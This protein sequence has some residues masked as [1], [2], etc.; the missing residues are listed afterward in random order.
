MNEIEKLKAE[1]EQL[2]RE[3]HW[4][5]AIL[6]SAPVLLSAKD[7]QGN[8]MFVSEHFKVLKGP[9]PDE[10]INKSVFD[11]FPAD[12]AEALWQND[13]EAQRSEFPVMAEEQVYHKD[14]QLHTYQ[15]SKFRLLRDEGQ[16]IGT[17]AVSFDITEL[18]RLEHDV[19]RDPLTGLYNRR[20]LDA[21]LE[22]ERQR[23]LREGHLLAF[24]LIDL[25]GFKQFNDQY[26]HHLGDEL[27][28]ALATT[29]RMWLR[30]SG[31]YCFR[32]GG[33]EFAA[34]FT[35]E[36][37]NDVLKIMNQVIESFKLHVAAMVPNAQDFGLSIG[38]RLIEMNDQSANRRLYIDADKALYKAKAMGKGQCQL[39]RSWSAHGE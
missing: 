27:L 17:C 9:D 21:S 6:K 33:D 18:K 10:Y 34:L 35:V 28:Q 5:Q 13:L 11:L 4:F 22:S 25:D 36:N 3:N 30:R 37:S 26:G 23:A 7:L 15:T 20:F 29:L 14:D 31:D 32:V 1:I 2:T 8:V 39:F 16:V 19:I 38:V 12:I 24:A